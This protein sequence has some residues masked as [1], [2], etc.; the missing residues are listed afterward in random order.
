MTG[1]DTTQ[2]LLSAG[3]LAVQSVAL[4]VSKAL[5]AAA[6]LGGSQHDP[7]VTHPQPFPAPPPDPNFQPHDRTLQLAGPLVYDLGGDQLD[8]TVVTITPPVLKPGDTGF[9]LQAVATGHR[10]GRYH[11]TVQ[12]LRPNQSLE[13]TVAVFVLV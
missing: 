9:T 1:K 3:T 11:G 5:D 4:I 10:S 2:N 7:V 8:A 13:A 6:E 12:V